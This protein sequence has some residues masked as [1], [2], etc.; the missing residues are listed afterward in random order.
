M[1]R[2]WYP[3]NQVFKKWLKEEGSNAADLSG[4]VQGPGVTE[5]LARTVSEVRNGQKSH[6]S[7]LKREGV[8]KNQETVVHT[9]VSRKGGR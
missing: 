5:T 4:V 8:M 1:R 3:E 2:V 7:A 9:A 6:W